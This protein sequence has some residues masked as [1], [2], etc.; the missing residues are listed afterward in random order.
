MTVGDAATRAREIVSLLEAGAFEEVLAATSDDVRRSLSAESLSAWPVGVGRAVGD[1]RAIADVETLDEGAARVLLRG[2]RGALDVIARFADG[3]LAS[4][5]V[6]TRVDDGIRNIVIGCPATPDAAR[7]LADFYALVLGFKIVREDWL[8][9]GRDLRAF[10]HLAFGDGWEDARPPRWRDPAFPH[11]MHLEAAATDLDE[12]TA[13]A[14]CAGGA[15]LEREDDAAV[16]ADP[17]GHPVVLR[18]EPQ[19]DT[20]AV[21]LTTVTMQCRDPDE[22]ASFWSGL[23]HFT[24]RREE[25]GNRIV[26][27]APERIALAFEGSPNYVP[28]R[29]HDP[30]FPEQVHLDLHFNDPDDARRRAEALGATPLPPPR[31]SCPVYADPAGHPFCVC[32]SGGGETAPYLP[33]IG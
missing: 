22:M 15:L 3:G 19:R 31:G 28:P 33:V 11:Q 5:G 18:S 32:S 4:L 13:A 29:W 6:T 23:L 24:D 7:Q 12:S 27:G 9:V 14:V 25:T 16:V 2:E 20:G 26:V 1:V 30:D 10:P 21:A 8:K 17:F